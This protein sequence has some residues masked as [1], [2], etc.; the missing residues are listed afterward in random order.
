MRN[1]RK[2][3]ERRFV[4][5]APVKKNKALFLKER[6]FRFEFNFSRGKKWV[7][8]HK[9]ISS[10]SALST[11]VIAFGILNFF[12]HAQAITLTPA[13]CL[14]GWTNPAYAEGLPQA[15]ATEGH[16]FTQENSAVLYNKI[17]EIFCGD[18]SGDIPEGA[19]PTR[20]TLSFSLA[21]KSKSEFFAEPTIE[22]TRGTP[23]EGII[24]TT[25]TLPE[26]N[27]GGEETQ[28]IEEKS[29][30][31]ILPPIENSSSSEMQS[32][33]AW[34]L[35]L[36]ARVFAQEENAPLPEAQT[37]TI[38]ENQNREIPPSETAQESASGTITSSS[39]TG[40]IEENASGTA[41]SSEA[42]ENSEEK[43]K[44]LYDFEYDSVIEVVWSTDGGEWQSLG[45][46][47]P[48]N[49]ENAKFTLPIESWESLQSLQVGLRSVLATDALP[50]VFLDAALLEIEFESVN[51][52][53]LSEEEMYMRMFEGLRSEQ[54]PPGFVNANITSLNGVPRFGVLL[55]FLNNGREELWLVGKKIENV[56]GGKSIRSDFPLGVKEQYVFWLSENK[57]I[58]YAYN[59]EKKFREE[60]PL[61]LP[62]GEETERRVV[63]FPDIPWEVIIAFDNFYFSREETGE[64]FSDSNSLVIQYFR[65]KMNLDE[66]LPKEKIESLG[67]PVFEEENYEIPTE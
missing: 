20:V 49:Y 6:V 1:P 16:S 54:M 9:I 35:N 42:G 30:E 53:E 66:S 25:S 7:V 28:I 27:E 65:G 29:E 40:I 67:M 14:G 44:G 56:D 26:G 62:I 55:K 22:E 61:P 45:Y 5:V 50:A 46:L 21:M 36:F 17:S 2:E 18:F 13:S 63:K 23:T 58:V 32:P 11:L 12:S 3:K 39:L 19:L 15:T 31:V 8:T 51:E 10:V 24:Q 38:S 60:V 57:D 43:K 48:R 37:E 33:S 47:N 64:V 34:F 41:S 4:D 59:I 52:P